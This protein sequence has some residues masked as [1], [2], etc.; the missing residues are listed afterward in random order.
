[1]GKLIKPGWFVDEDH[2][3]TVRH[4]V[5]EHGGHPYE[6][7]GK[8]LDEFFKKHKIPVTRTEPKRDY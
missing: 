2:A 4:L 1:M 8:A 3:K 5:A 7:C 6:I